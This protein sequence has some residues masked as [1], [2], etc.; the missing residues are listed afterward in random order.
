MIT[1]NTLRPHEGLEM[2]TPASRYCV[3]PRSYPERLAPI[4]Y[5]AQDVLRKVGPAGY[6]SWGNQ[7]FHVGRAF[8]GD[9]VAMRPVLHDGIHEVYYCHQPIAIIDGRDGSCQQK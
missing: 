2:K 9:L 1:Y 6:I 3:S 4:E 7:R 8:S 5:L